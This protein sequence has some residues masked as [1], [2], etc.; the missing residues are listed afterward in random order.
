MIP[1]LLRSRSTFL[2][3]S[4]QAAADI[5]TNAKAFSR[6]AD[7]W[8]GDDITPRKSSKESGSH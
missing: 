6:G 1:S 3:L 8:V 7:N 2:K 4:F 5:R